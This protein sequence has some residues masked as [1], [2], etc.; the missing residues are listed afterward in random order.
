MAPLFPGQAGTSQSSEG[1]SGRGWQSG[2]FGG[3]AALI[4]PAPPPTPVTGISLLIPPDAIPRGKIYEIYLTLHK[5]EGIEVW[6]WALL[7]GLGGS[8]PSPPPKVGSA[9]ALCLRT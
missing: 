7:V 6:A 8:L 5:P 2:V 1:G 4:A 3:S 9:L